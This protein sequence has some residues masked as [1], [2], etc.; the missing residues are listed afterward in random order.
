MSYLKS[1]L[2]RGERVVYRARHHWILQLRELFWLIVW[3]AVAAALFLLRQPLASWLRG[4]L[5]SEGGGIAEGTIALIIGGLAVLL[6]LLRIRRVISFYVFLWSTEYAVTTRRVIMKRGLIR[7]STYE[8][9]LSQLESAQVDQGL[10]GRLLGY[11]TLSLNATGGSRGSWP[12]IDNPVYFK[13]AIETTLGT[14]MSQR[15]RQRSERHRSEP[16]PTPAASEDDDQPGVFLVSGVR[17]ES[18]EDDEMTIEA[19][20]GANARVKAEM[21]GLVVTSVRRVEAEG[22]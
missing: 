14:D 2:V 10:L 17:K 3:L 21:A 1:S 19:K 16:A 13:R 11:G 7:R 8:V 4:A 9:Q 18:Q 15:E 22:V 12:A 6:A 5:F 20:S